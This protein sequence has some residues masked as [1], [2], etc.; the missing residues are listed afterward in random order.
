MATK[1]PTRLILGI[2][3]TG[4]KKPNTFSF[5]L[6]L[7]PHKKAI[8]LQPIAASA[9]HTHWSRCCALPPATRG[10]HD[11]TF[12]GE[13][14][15]DSP[16]NDQNHWPPWLWGHHI[17]QRDPMFQSS[18]LWMVYDVYGGLP[19]WIQVE[20]EHHWAVE[21]E[22][23]NRS[24]FSWI[25]YR[26]WLYMGL[27]NLNFPSSNSQ[28]SGSNHWTRIIHQPLVNSTY[29]KSPFLRGK[30]SF[31]YIYI[32]TYIIYKCTSFYSEII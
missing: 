7:Y 3:D 31:I 12:Q 30:L 24:N 6:F 25:R 17:H 8:P 14:W 2:L 20:L 9:R 18:K 11:Q 23:R 15:E 22:A 16:K 26:P 32:Y 13:R 28:T 4:L 10:A 29:W 21:V 19:H 5:H 27:S 1:P